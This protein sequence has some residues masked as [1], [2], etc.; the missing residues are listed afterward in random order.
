MKSLGRLLR[1]SIES[2]GYTIYRAASKAGV[3]RTTLQKVL[4]DDRP[5]SQEFL[6]LLLPIL[7]LSPAEEKDIKDLFEISQT[8]ESLYLQRRYIQKMLNSM[9]DLDFLPKEAGGNLHRFT[10]YESNLFKFEQHIIYGVYNVEQLLRVLLA[11]E[12]SHENP[13]IYINVPGNL[14]IIDQFFTHNLS[15]CNNL[16][17]L[18]IRHITNLIKTP[19]ASANP[20]INLDIL[21]KIFPFTIFWNLNYKIYYYYSNELISDTLNVAFPYYILFGNAAVLLNADGTTALPIYD[22]VVVQYF[23]NLFTES[24]K[25]T[26]TL[27]TDC[28]TSIGILDYLKE[29]D[30]DEKSRST[31]KFQ[32]CLSAFLTESMIHKYTCYDI[33]NRNQLI[34]SVILQIQQISQFKNHTCIFSQQGLSYFIQTGIITD[35]P[36]DF[37]S[38][39]EKSDRIQLLRSLYDSCRTDKIILRMANPITFSFSKHLKCNLRSNWGLDFSGFDES[40]KH[41]RYIHIQEHTIREAFEDFF[42]YLLDS[43]LVYSKKETLDEILNGIK[44]LSI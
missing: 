26:F 44:D 42:Q 34:Q 8:G 6:S 28:I 4:S 1:N 21:S 43:E 32:P 35:F 36:T 10:L 17:N 3:N 33:E 23:Q 41:F 40:G 7:K 38:P 39:M 30:K 11:K 15:Y 18:T 13:T 14:D 27:V 37:T 20:L 9:S 12:C 25:H 19:E 31:I 29:A 5:A 2:S 24:L 16:G 22:A